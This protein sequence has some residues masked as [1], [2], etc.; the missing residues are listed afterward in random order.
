MS[1]LEKVKQA[2]KKEISNII[3]GELKDPRIGFVTVT[4][5]ELT[6][7]LRFAKI[8]YSVLG[9]SVEKEKAGLAIEN[10]KGFIRRLIS[11]NIDLRF[12]PELIF[13]EDRSMEYS[14]RIQE[15]LEKLKQTHE[16]KK[17]NRRNK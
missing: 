1:R 13:K 2:I 3:H 12:T 10:A 5:V 8:Y 11:Q 16:F 6:K 15:E 9:S 17:S 4:R 7:D 14:I